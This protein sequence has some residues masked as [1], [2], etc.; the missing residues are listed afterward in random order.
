MPEL[1]TLTDEA[2]R[3][4]GAKEMHEAIRS[5][6]TRLIVRVIIRD[7]SGKYLLQ[8]RAD[9]MMTF[10]GYWDVSAA[11]HVDDGETTEVAARR[12]LSEE[13]GIANIELTKRAEYYV[14]SRDRD[15]LLRQYT[16]VFIGQFD[17]DIAGMT[18]DTSEVATVAW[19]SSDGLN[20]LHPIME[21]ARR[22]IESV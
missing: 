11:G 5:G 21:E 10:P 17:S 13:L 12:E 22:A 4:I 14:E 18:I 3:R 8:K 1:V 19:V 9:N 20:G 7:A 2:G 6:D 15:L 16:H